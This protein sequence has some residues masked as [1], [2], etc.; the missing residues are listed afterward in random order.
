MR[1]S[2]RYP[3]AAWA[4]LC[5][6]TG[7]TGTS[8]LRTRVSSTG[9][10]RLSPLVSSRR[11]SEA[12]GRCEHAPFGPQVM[13][14]VIFERAPPLERSVMAVSQHKLL[15]RFSCTHRQCLACSPRDQFSIRPYSQPAAFGGGGSSA[16]SSHPANGG[17]VSSGAGA[18]TCSRAEGPRVFG[19]TPPPSDRCCPPCGKGCNSAEGRGG[20]SADVKGGK[21]LN[22]PFDA[23]DDSC[24]EDFGSFGRRWMAA[25]ARAARAAAW[26]STW[27]C[28]ASMAASVSSRAP[29]ASKASR[30]SLARP[31]VTWRLWIWRRSTREA[32][33]DV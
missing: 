31:S 16:D 18:R 23:F 9:A 26:A 4:T 3:P 19:A 11:R 25:A 28:L 6:R 14:I 8:L 13:E 30:G 7:H 32:Q 10:G 27:A 20:K 22:E 29:Q 2:S 5:G 33:R 24:R 17:F 12:A 21:S 1:R 15:F